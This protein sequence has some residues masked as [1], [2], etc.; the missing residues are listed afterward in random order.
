MRTASMTSSV[1]A[2]VP[3][4]A[5][6]SSCRGKRTCLTRLACP[7]RLVHDDWSAPWKKTHVTRPES[8]KSG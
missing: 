5:N 2:F 6:G 8:R 1:M 3:T 7:S 4:T